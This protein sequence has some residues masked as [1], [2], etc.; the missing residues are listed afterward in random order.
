MMELRSLKPAGGFLLAAILAL[1]AG[2]MGAT[3]AKAQSSGL[4]G[5]WGG[6]G[7]IVFPSGERERARCRA[8]FHSQGR[9]GYRM[10]A[11]CATSSARVQQ[12]AH[13][14]HVGGNVYRGDFFNEEHGI[15]GTV[16]IQVRGNRLDASLAG[17]GGSAAF[18]L[19]R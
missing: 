5:S 13:I 3:E 1:S 8:S 7:Q 11:V 15:T 9:K 16:R 4:S 6:G 17:G 10:N 2:G 12:V 14:R 19:K 18:V